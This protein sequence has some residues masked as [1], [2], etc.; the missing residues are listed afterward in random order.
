MNR[1]LIALFLVVA[2]TCAVTSH[3]QIDFIPPQVREL[4]NMHR[5]CD[6][7]KGGRFYMLEII[8]VYGDYV[9]RI[10]KRIEKLTG[11]NVDKGQKPTPNLWFR[12]AQAPREIGQ[13]I[14][15]KG[16]SNHNGFNEFGLIEEN[17]TLM[18]V[19]RNERWR[20]QASSATLIG[21]SLSVFNF[22]KWGYF[23]DHRTKGYTHRRYGIYLQDNE[24]SALVEGDVDENGLL[25]ILVREFEE[26]RNAKVA[27]MILDIARFFPITSIMEPEAAKR[28]LLQIQRTSARSGFVSNNITRRGRQ[29]TPRK[30]SF[31]QAVLRAGL[32]ASI[33][34]SNDFSA[35]RGDDAYAVYRYLA[36]G[37]A[38]PGPSR[39]M[40]FKRCMA[41][42]RGTSYHDNWIALLQSGELPMPADER[43]QMIEQLN[44]EIDSRSMGA[45]TILSLSLLG[46]FA[47]GI[48]LLRVIS[49]RVMFL[50]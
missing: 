3:G 5:S 19:N 1:S 50:S 26:T 2:S 7:S 23:R 33:D 18:W 48:F 20:S 38:T 24:E 11:S 22:K 17:G 39:T 6:V 49:R 31:E 36:E 8:A 21:E 45:L 15:V 28:I 35:D 29:E 4:T 46:A 13:D 44:I 47:F 25:E 27:A 43:D 14:V 41:T 42:P 37:D 30:N 16:G 9:D 40:A 12:V 32:E 10:D 34:T